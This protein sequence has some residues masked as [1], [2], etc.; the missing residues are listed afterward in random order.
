M[1]QPQLSRR[2]ARSP[3]ARASQASTRHE[4]V[5]YLARFEDEDIDL[6]SQMRY[7][8]SPQPECSSIVVMV[9]AKA[10]I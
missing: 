1:T 9:V 6:S 10:E 3:H 4:L 2:A 7:Y 8:Q 5:V